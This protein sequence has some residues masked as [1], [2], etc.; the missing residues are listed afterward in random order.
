MLQNIAENNYY[1]KT[2]TINCCPFRPLVHPLPWLKIQSAISRKNEE[3]L[4]FNFTKPPC[5]DWLD[6]GGIY[7]LFITLVKVRFFKSH[8]LLPVA[9]HTSPIPLCTGLE[10]RTRKKDQLTRKEH[11]R[12]TIEGRVTGLGGWEELQRKSKEC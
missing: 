3:G 8:F 10:I 2:G 9:P 4:T 1:N 7:Y 6:A 5:P 11:E 12:G